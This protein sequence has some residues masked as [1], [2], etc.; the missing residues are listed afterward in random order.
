MVGRTISHYRIVSTLGRGGM[1]V[2]Y[3]AE[4][5]RLGRTVA[6][7]F[8]PEN[9]AQNPQALERF[10]R[11][12]RSASAL[13]HP[14]ICTI[15]DIDESDGEPFLVME[16]LEGE[17]LHKRLA[18]GPLAIR[19]LVTFGIQV[20]DGLQA[21]HSKKIVHRDLKPANLF[22][23]DRGIAKILDF[24]LARTT[25]EMAE[26]VGGPTQQTA[27]IAEL[28][29]PGTTLGTI[30]YM[31]PEQARGEVVDA[32]TDLFSLGVVLYQAATGKMPF[33]GGNQLAVMHAILH[34]EPRPPR[35]IRPDL[36]PEVEH[37]ILR[38]LQKDR[39]KRYPSADGLLE[40]LRSYQASLSAPVTAEPAMRILRRQ[41][42]R[43]LTIAGIT[44]LV[45]QNARVRWART[46]AIPEIV[47]LSDR[48]EFGAAYKLL[49]Q[50]EKYLPNDPLLDKLLT[51]ISM[52]R[53][54]R[55]TPPGADVFIKDYNAPQEDWERIGLSPVENFRL[56]AISFRVR[57]TKPGF[58]PVEGTA[59]IG[60]SNLPV[61]LDS[62]GSIPPEMVRVPG[63]EI[64]QE[65]SAEPVRL[66]AYLMDRYEVTNRQFKEFVDKGGYQD[67][68]YW[69]EEFVRDGRKLSWEEASALLRDSTG[70]P[71]PSTW[72]L[73]EYP[74][75]QDDF[76]VSGVSWYEAAAYAEFAGK[77]LPTVY[78]WRNATDAGYYTGILKISNFAG[79]GPARV[80]S[81][82]GVGPFGT[83]DMAGNVKE[84]C[85]SQSG[86]QHYILGGA[87]NEPA[88]T[89]N[90]PDAKPPFDRSPTNGFRCVKYLEKPPSDAILGE[91]H[92]AERDYRKEKPVPAETFRIYQSLYSYDRTE[93]K[94]AVE[95][96]DESSAYW[97]E[98]KIT[99]NAAYGNERVIAYLL[100]PKR[101]TPP[102]QTIVFFPA[103]DATV[104]DSFKT[105]HMKF[106]DF[107]P[108]S[109]R[110]LLV[111]IYKG[112][113]ERRTPRGPGGPSIYRDLVIAQAK[114]F[115]R[116]LDYLETRPDIDK[117]R[118]GYYGF[119]LGGKLG[120]IMTAG[121]P[122][123]KAI[124]L[125]SG[126]LSLGKRLPEVDEINFLPHVTAP[127][128]MANGRYDFQFALETVQI[129]MFRLLGAAEKDK[130]HAMLDAGHI[131]DLQVTIKETL[132]WYDRY[133][134][135]V[136]TSSH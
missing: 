122:R 105:A 120:P 89:F 123:I 20:A 124:V 103:G 75:G 34:E 1:G 99:F 121:E 35:E 27:T 126:G 116:S 39:E 42:K 31:S 85:W 11:E 60:N 136:A 61:V 80:G 132:A 104:V 70:R 108:R 95:S 130:R 97:R 23:T 111:P 79:T 10:R 52:P 100:L 30:A 87:W 112:T 33:A 16:L 133:L 9:F 106:W 4:D 18:A 131:P 83:Y 19:D 135:P 71:G 74:Q 66:D 59:G 21:A 36:P 49:R 44:L 90:D 48:G 98:E 92:R 50:T 37:I 101:A 117:G 88:Y 109:N 65:I 84:W 114:D 14:H 51:A 57:M 12:A 77:Q 55:T 67:R 115:R 93:L 107:I 54:F 82:L 53:S 91:F 13:N 63:G 118:L 15:H 46:V 72:E 22:I 62:E 43:P 69:K 32:R 3:E 64:R 102:Y 26:T 113:Y 81:H 24:G 127:V 94:P 78:H 6:M 110:A 25:T 8:L 40:D 17:T 125:I 76:P 2:V 56:P 45:R 5:T 47:R 134:G 58:R 41:L 129:P 7:K 73:G 38:A 96:V 128:L 86:G 68:K 28:T 29:A 119:S